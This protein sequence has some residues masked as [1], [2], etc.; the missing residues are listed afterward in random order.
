MAIAA[1]ASSIGSTIRRI[2]A[3]RATTMPACNRNSVAPIAWV[4]SSA[5]APASPPALAPGAIGAGVAARHRL[6]T[7]ARG[8][9]VADAL[10]AQAAIARP[11]SGRLLQG[12]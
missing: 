9:N 1:P 10:D 4:A 7:G 5:R 8:A 3:A 6:G 2:E 12:M 11:C